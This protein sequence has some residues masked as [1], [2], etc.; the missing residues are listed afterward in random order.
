VALLGCWARWSLPV[1]TMRL[2]EVVRVMERGQ[3]LYRCW[4]FRR[5]A[6]EVL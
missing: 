4:T 5:P 3:L 6:W 2:L 1:V